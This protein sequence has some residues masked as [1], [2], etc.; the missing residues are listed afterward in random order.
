[1]T[2]AEREGTELMLRQDFERRLPARL[3]RQARIPVHPCLP[4]EFFAQA[5]AECRHLFFDE[6]Y[7]GCIVLTQSVAEGVARFVAEKKCPGDKSKYKKRVEKLLNSVKPTAISQKVHDAFL[8]VHGHD[9]NDFHHL[10]SNI[11]QDRRELEKRAEECLVA[12][13]EIQSELFA[14]PVVKP[15]IQDFVNKEYWSL[16]AHGRI[17]IYADC[18]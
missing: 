11:E 13:F 10:N 4:T 7:Y 3:D 5:S 12:L 16:D 15:G 6:R 9:R 1:M 2:D 14:C 17:R 18:G 8:R